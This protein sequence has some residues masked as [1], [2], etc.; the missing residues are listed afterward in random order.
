V[1]G[2]RRSSSTCVNPCWLYRQGF[3]YVLLVGKFSLPRSFGE[4]PTLPD[5]PISNDVSADL[6]MSAR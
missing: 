2:A 1:T 5:R 6:S 4:K 3:A